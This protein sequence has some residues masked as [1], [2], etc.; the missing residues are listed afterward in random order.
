MKDQTG[1]LAMHLAAQQNSSVDVVRLL[2]E[3]GGAEQL[4]VKGQNGRLPRRGQS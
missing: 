3:T 2:L 4:Q 1:R